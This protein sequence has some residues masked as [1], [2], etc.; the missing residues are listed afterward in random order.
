MSSQPFQ[1]PPPGVRV[2]LEADHQRAGEIVCCPRSTVTSVPG[3]FSSSL[4]QLDVLAADLCG[5]QA[6]L[7]GVAPE[8]VGEPRAR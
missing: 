5:E 6:A 4:K 8:D 2:D 3:S 1:Q 7:A